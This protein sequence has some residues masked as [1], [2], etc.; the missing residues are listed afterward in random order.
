MAS[1]RSDQKSRPRGVAQPSLICA[2]TS[3]SRG[4][5][6]AA[7]QDFRD[8]QSSISNCKGTF[9]LNDALR[10]WHRSIKPADSAILATAFVPPDRPFDLAAHKHRAHIARIGGPGGHLSRVPNDLVHFMCK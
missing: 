9:E 8:R 10:H 1:A 6:L 4:P 2:T 3:L 7:P 5:S